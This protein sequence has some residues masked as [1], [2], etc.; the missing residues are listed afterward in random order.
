MSYAVRHVVRG[1]T[2]TVVADRRT[3]RHMQAGATANYYDM[4]RSRELP[5]A[6]AMNWRLLSI[7]V[8]AYLFTAKGYL[9]VSDTAP[10]VQTAESVVTRGKL[11]VPE[12]PGTFPGTDGRFY[13]KYGL[14]LALAF[15]P[16][17]AAAHAAARI[18]HQSEPELAAFFISFLNV[19]F[20]LLVLWTFGRLLRRFG[21][22]E[23]T[24]TLLI[25]ALGLGTLSWRYAVYDFSEEM[26]AALLLLAIDGVSRNTKQGSIGAGAALA[27]LV[28]VKVVHVIFVPIFLVYEFARSGGSVVRRVRS[29]AALALPA[30]CGILILMMLNAVRFGNPLVSGYGSEGHDFALNR[31]PFTIPALLVSLDK[32][33]F[34]F[35]PVLLVGLLGWPE[36]VRTRRPEA[37]LFGALIVCNLLINAAFVGWRGGWSWGPRYLVPLLPL[38]LLPAALWIQKDRSMRRFTIAAA[39]ACM[40]IAAQVPGVFVKDQEIHHIRWNVLTSAES[41]YMAS[42]WPAGWI[43]LFHKVEGKPERYAATEFGVPTDRVIDV[44]EFRTFRGFNIWTVQLAAQLD[45]PALRW[46]SPLALIVALAL[47]ARTAA[48]LWT[49]RRGGLSGVSPDVGRSEVS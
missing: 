47:L 5:T 12:E 32:G 18:A 19:P 28:V 39:I 7:F 46:L 40:S 22:R 25:L 20:A 33:L 49:L 41:P 3:W 36:F 35:C 27:A 14:G 31:L 26:Q 8:L 11:D 44:E 15:V 30:M 43:L 21:V 23:P 42:D 13:S 6:A 24:I 45:R 10:S 38:W 4:V 2:A 34:V 29:A 16:E 1:S 48:E 9:E 17:V 37:L